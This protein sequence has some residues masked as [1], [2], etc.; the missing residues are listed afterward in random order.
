VR[1][2]V[3]DRTGAGDS[4]FETEVRLPSTNLIEGEEVKLSV[5]ST[6]DAR[7]YV[8]GI[9]DDGATVLLPNAY[10]PDTRVRAGPGPKGKGSKRCPYS[11]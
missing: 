2:R 6:K 3:L 11:R 1:G 8:I 5:R 9:T 10:H 7:I 4:G